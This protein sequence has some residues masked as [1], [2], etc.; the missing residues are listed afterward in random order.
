[1]APAPPCSPAP[2]RT[3]RAGCSP[4]ACPDDPPATPSYRALRTHLPIHLRR[5]SSAALGSQ[6][7]EL[8]A[9]VLANLLDL[10]I[11]TANAWADY[12]QHGW[13]VYLA[14]RSQS[15]QAHAATTFP[16]HR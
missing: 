16:A 6:A 3:D 10:N 7:A 15:G 14:A 2:P 9:A 8:P 11:N 12:A 5:D 4:A 13:S 1:V